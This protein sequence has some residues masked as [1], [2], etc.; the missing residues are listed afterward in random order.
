[1]F[2]REK[3]NAFF[4]NTP[5]HL[6]M[7]YKTQWIRLFN[8]IKNKRIVQMWFGFFTDGFRKILF[9][10]TKWYCRRNR[11]ARRQVLL[12]ERPTYYERFVQSTRRFPTTTR[13]ILCKYVCIVLIIKSRK[14]V[15][16][17]SEFYRYTDA[18]VHT[19][20][21]MRQLSIS[22]R[23]ILMLCVLLHDDILRNIKPN[24]K[25]YIGHRVSSIRSLCL[26]AFLWWRFMDR[27]L[28][29]N[30]FSLF[31]LNH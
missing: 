26:I 28:Y 25:H 14:N 24:T 23:C 17:H 4:L 15:S 1:M 8:A 31:V 9:V 11:I 6:L 7:F 13:C 16:F 18:A 5:E 22:R 19:H 2:A 10:A 29:Y 20:I 12:Q 21:Y 27:N 30:F 3:W